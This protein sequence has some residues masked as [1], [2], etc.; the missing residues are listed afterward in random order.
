MMVTEF[1]FMHRIDGLSKPQRVVVIIALGLALGVLGSYLAGLGGGFDVAFLAHGWT[2][3]LTP[4]P[5]GLRDL[6]TMITWLVLIA[7]WALG[8]VRLLRPSSANA[9]SD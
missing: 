3:P 7:V 2:Q 5:S 9:A 8:S 6:L 1:G 4:A